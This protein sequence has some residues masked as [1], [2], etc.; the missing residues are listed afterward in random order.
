MNLVGPAM[1]G[2]QQAHYRSQSSAPGQC[3]DNRLTSKTHHQHVCI[4]MFNLHCISNVKAFTLKQ[5][6]VNTWCPLM[7]FLPFSAGYSMQSVGDA[8]VSWLGWGGGE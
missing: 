3:I 5:W 6:F 7:G 2:V 4:H 8:G 1:G